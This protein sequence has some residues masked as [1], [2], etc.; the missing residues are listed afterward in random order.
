MIN[1]TINY[2][3]RKVPISI[4]IR[5]AVQYDELAS[6][7]AEKLTINFSRYMEKYQGVTLT[8]KSRQKYFLSQYILLKY[9][10]QEYKF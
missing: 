9:K 10:L 2:Q 5:G 8:E 1:L 7:V 6:L 4:D 3:G